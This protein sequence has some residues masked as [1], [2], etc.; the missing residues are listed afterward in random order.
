MSPRLLPAIGLTALLFTLGATHAAANDGAPPDARQ[1]FAEAQKVRVAGPAD[2]PLAGQAV[3]HLPAGE[4]FIPQP[5]AAK[6]MVAMGNPGQH[7]DLQG[8]V[9]PQGDK[10]EWFA[11]LRYIAS[12][13]IKDGDAKE[14][15]ADDMLKSFREGTEAA[16]EERAKMGVTP[17]EIVGWAEKPAYAADTHRLVWAMASREK[18]APADAARGVNYNTYALGREGYISINLVTELSE[19]PQ[20]KHVAHELLAGLEFDKGKAYADF[21]G[22]T[23]HVAEYGLAALVVGVGAKKLGLLAVVFAFLAKFA[24]L[25]I[26]AVAGVGAAAARLFKRKDSKTDIPPQA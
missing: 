2:I 13:Y 20:Q 17:L 7:A 1:A 9:F 26:L 18:G 5:Q 23:D 16:N 19:L 15:D 10:E 3:L 4:V 24:K 11:T 8:L 22:S 6:V 12:G 14:W 21:N 25:A